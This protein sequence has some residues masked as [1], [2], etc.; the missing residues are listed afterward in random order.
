M[1]KLEKNIIK[2]IYQKFKDF[3][4]FLIT[5]NDNPKIE[6]SKLKIQ[7]IFRVMFFSTLIFIIISSY[8]SMTGT[9]KHLGT[10]FIFT[11]SVSI[12]LVW[13]FIEIHYRK[14]REKKLFNL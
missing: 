7:E 1:V 12:F 11:G 2:K 14:K 5:K 8:G 4:E 10:S 9:A 13:A 6:D 3:D